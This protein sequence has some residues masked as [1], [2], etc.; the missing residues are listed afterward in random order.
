MT[1]GATSGD[2]VPVSLRYLFGKNITVHGVYVGPKTAVPQYLK[3][4]PHTLRPVIDS[5]FPFEDAQKAYEKLLSRQVFGKIVV[6]V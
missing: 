3:L 4:M 6:R 5:V 1:F 2:Q